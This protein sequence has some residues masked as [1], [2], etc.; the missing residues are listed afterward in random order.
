VNFPRGNGLVPQRRPGVY[1]GGMTFSLRDFR[2]A[3]LETLWSID[4]DCFPPGIAYSRRELNIFVRLWRSF[5]LVAESL[6][7]GRGKNGS[8]PSIKG[9]L[10]AEAR[11]GAGH[12]ITIDVLPA[13]R[14][15]GLGSQLLAAA[16]VRLLAAGC[17]E[18]YLETSVDNHSA[19]AFYK[20]HNYRTVKTVPQYY[21]NG[22]DAL[23]LT[24][25]LLSQAQ[26]S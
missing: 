6:P 11:R 14:R 1:N 20:R 2:R 23:V 22:M 25:D 15:A 7:A 8:P 5:T 26:A 19:L 17:R 4:Q 9:F 13:A 10:V 18:V 3:D 16:E 12:I 24:K 21:S